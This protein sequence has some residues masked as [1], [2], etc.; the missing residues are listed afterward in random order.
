MV[1][2]TVHEQDVGRVLILCNGVESSVGVCGDSSGAQGVRTI[3]HPE[4]GL[5]GYGPAAVTTHGWDDRLGFQ[6]PL[7]GSGMLA[8]ASVASIS[9]HH[10]LPQPLAPRIL[11]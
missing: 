9:C 2:P 8:S 4:Q 11:Y 1:T 7:L 10:P 5:R 6:W 3:P